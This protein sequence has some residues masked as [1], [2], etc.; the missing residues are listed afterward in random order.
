MDPW[1]RLGFGFL[2]VSIPVFGSAR[3]FPRGRF[4]VRSA[5][6]QA[7]LRALLRLPVPCFH[8]SAGLLAAFSGSS[9]AAW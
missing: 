7:R 1:Q 5:R 4:W 3:F 9:L 2:V 8:F 6:L